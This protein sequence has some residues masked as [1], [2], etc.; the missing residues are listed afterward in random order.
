MLYVRQEFDVDDGGAFQQNSSNVLRRLTSHTCRLKPL[1][2]RLSGPADPDATWKEML[3]VAAWLKDKGLKSSQPW[4][5]HCATL[6]VCQSSSSA[7]NSLPKRGESQTTAARHVNFGEL[8]LHQTVFFHS[9]A[10]SNVRLFLTTYRSMIWTE[11]AIAT[12]LA[13]LAPSRR[14]MK[15]ILACDILLQGAEN[16]ACACTVMTDAQTLRID[17]ISSRERLG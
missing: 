11:P 16:E 2:S 12:K 10:K 13:T 9:A 6:P 3:N 15:A 4:Y 5:D 8:P 7:W 1:K 17:K 14:A